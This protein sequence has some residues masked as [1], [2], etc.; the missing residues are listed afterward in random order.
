[1]AIEILEQAA[2]N[3]EKLRNNPY[4]GRGIIVGLD[5]SGK[6]LV[7]ASFVTGRSEGSRNRRYKLGGY[8]Y[9]H[10]EVADPSQET[11][12]PEKTIYAAMGGDSG[13]Y[14]V[15]NGR[16]TNTV[17]E[18][19]GR[20]HSVYAAM[21]EHAY[22]DDPISTPRITG[23]C[24]I[25]GKIPLWV[26]LSILRKSS[27]CDSCER[28]F[29]QFEE[30]CP[31][32]GHTLTT[33]LTD[34]DPPPPFQGEP[35]VLPLIFGEHSAEDIATGLWGALNKPNRVCLAV[36]MVDLK[37]GHMVGDPVLINQY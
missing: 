23:V 28:N 18:L 33:Y 29:F 27:F 6:Y 16:Q 19:W 25:N 35:Y 30:L 9:V 11:G 8:G 37:T 31:G 26:M 15:S 20:E 17:A 7:Q 14:V 21:L 12:D 34:G 1:M 36:K 24:V 10:T 4:P 32:I 5:A 2:A 3:L 22:E 13:V